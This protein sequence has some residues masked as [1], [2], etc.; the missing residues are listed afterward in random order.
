MSS[1]Q[2]QTPLPLGSDEHP[3]R[4]ETV[5][6]GGGQAGLAAAHWLAE[7]GSDFLVVEAAERVGDQWRQ[8]YDSLRL[9][10]P[11]IANGLPGAPFPGPR[12]AF[13]SAREL[14]DYLETYAAPFADQILKGTRVTRV[15]A[16][17]DGGFRVATSAGTI[18]A[19]H[20]VVATGSDAEP[21]IPEVTAL[22]D[23]GIRQ[24]H[25][26][27][28]QNPDQLLPG[29]VLVVGA[30][31]SGADLALE[32]VRSG[33]ETWLSGRHP[34]EIPGNE[35]VRGPL[36]WLVSNYVLTL[37]NP[38]GRR[39]RPK[40][41]SGSAPL[42]RTKRRDLDAAGIHRTQARTV[43][44]VDGKPQLDDG[45]VLDVAN[46]LWCT[47]YRGDYSFLPVGVQIGTDGFPAEHDGAADGVPGLYFVGLMFQRTFASHLVGGVGKDAKVVADMIHA[48]SLAPV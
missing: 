32:A 22:L 39:V 46:V 23:P 24:L 2:P 38:I 20:V 30:G 17:D 1:I 16:L 36:F 5:I 7:S 25:S 47:G 35:F 43:G 6:V 3:R 8:R 26:S 4:V 31:T 19:A 33:H 27:R 9:F 45:T 10:T 13:P 12:F 15:D 29:P 28:Y 42:V 18:D 34:G 44:A 41:R 48:R 14:G 21:K 11:A 40:I 37:K